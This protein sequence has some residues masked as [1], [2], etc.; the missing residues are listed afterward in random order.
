MIKK[1]NLFVLE[2]TKQIL[3]ADKR[4]KALYKTYGRDV[5][6]IVLRGA[7]GDA[8]LQLL[9]LDE[10]IRQKKI[11]NYILTGDASGIKGLIQ[12]FDV[13]QYVPADHYEI[14]C[15]ERY[16]L[17]CNDPDLNIHFMF[18]WNYVRNSFNR[19][20]VRMLDGFSFIDTYTFFSLGLTGEVQYRK[21]HFK[22]CD[23]DDHFKWKKLGAVKGR[24]VIISPEANSV[25]M[26]PIWLWNAIISEL[27]KKN[28]VVLLNCDHPNGYKAKDVFFSYYESKGFLEYCGAFLAIRS[29]LCDIV[30]TCECKKIILYPEKMHSVN[31]SEHRSEMEFSSFE[32]MPFAYKEDLHEISTPLMTNITEKDTNIES[33]EQYYS[34]LSQLKD[35]I[36]S[37]F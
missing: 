15:L 32:Y 12:V 36:L 33:F 30:S 27:E 6:I 28:Y 8:F 9:Y 7:T 18:T 4:V 19:C 1:Q 11:K 22:E 16:S 17:F 3:H 23:E 31:Y 26:L 34:A 24:T 20:R 35:Q 37:H 21:M 25:S 10:F 29:G 13:P 2:R 14:D 5:A